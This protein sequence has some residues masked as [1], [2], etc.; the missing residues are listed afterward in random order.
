MRKRAFPEREKYAALKNV[1]WDPLL[2]IFVPPSSPN[3]L[4]NCYNCETIYIFTLLICI[5]LT[6]NF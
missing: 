5:K 4:S 6:V 3:P 1:P 2:P